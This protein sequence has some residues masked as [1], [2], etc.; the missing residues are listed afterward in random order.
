MA[1]PALSLDEFFGALSFLGIGTVPL[2]PVADEQRKVLAGLAGY[3]PLR[4]AATFGGLLTLPELQSNCIRLEVLVHLSLALAGGARKP[5]D[6]LVA[7]LFTALGDGI[8]GRQEDPA[9]DVF[10]SLI[11][12][13]RGNF[14]ILEG[15]WEASGFYLERVVN[16]LELIPPGKRYDHMREAVY[17][18]L[19]L[20]DAVCERAKLTRYELGNTVAQDSLSGKI[21]SGLSSLRRTIRFTDAEL[22]ALGISVEHLGE[23]GFDAATRKGLIDDKIGHST[24]ERYPL[25][26]RNGKVFVLLPTAISPAIRR[27]VIEEL[28]TPKLREAFAATLGIAYTTSSRT[29]RSWDFTPGRPH[30]FREQRR[31]CLLARRHASIAVSTSIL[32]SSSIRL[33]ASKAMAW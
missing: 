2:R 12:T 14:R 1:E 27:Y 30:N 20:S 13:R 28:D 8:A 33:M 18:L 29:P 21:L 16:S 32:C 22:K 15:V 26:Y 10:V 24:L 23:F 6:K 5:N 17:G 7:Q 4:L 25:A 11:R 3:D 31:A 9:E 19:R